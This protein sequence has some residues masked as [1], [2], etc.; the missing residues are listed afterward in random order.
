MPVALHFY[1]TTSGVF[2]LNPFPTAGRF[3]EPFNYNLSFP[4]DNIMLLGQSLSYIPEN[5]KMK[6]SLTTLLSLLILAATVRGQ[7]P[8]PTLTGLAPA[9]ALANA[10]QWDAALAALPQAAP[11][12]LGALFLRGQILYQKHDYVQAIEPLTAVV[13]ALPPASAASRQSVQMLA[14]SHYLLGHLAESIPYLAQVSDWQ[15]DNEQLSYAL[16]VAYIQTRQP[17]PAR[18]V[19]ARMFGVAPAS[20]AAYLLNAQML[21]RQQ[22]EETAQDELAKALEIDPKLPQANYLLGEM[23]VYKADLERGV[24]LFHKEIALNPAFGMAYYRLGEAYTRQL[25]WDAAFAPLQKSI[26]LNPYFSGPYIV[27]GKVY[28]KKSDF[29]NAENILRRA[30][31]IDPNNFA[32]HNL[33]AQTLQQAGRTDEAKKEFALSEQLRGQA[34]KEP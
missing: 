22:F 26:W 31:R 2:S 32:A 15:P 23:A 25:K 27:L 34:D 21:I 14:M 16:G 20:A 19:F 17:V 33:L 11:D 4:G 29:V 7:Q 30:V 28:L 3:A 8:T 10:G 5:R 1:K 9:Q 18:L 24:Q 12:D 6:Y 13:K